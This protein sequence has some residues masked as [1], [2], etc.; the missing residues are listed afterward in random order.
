VRLY[1]KNIF[2]KNSPFRVLMI[3][4]IKRLKEIIKLVLVNISISK[5]FIIGILSILFIYYLTAP[6]VYFYLGGGRAFIKLFPRKWLGDVSTLVTMKF[7]RPVINDF[8]LLTSNNL[9]C[10]ENLNHVPFNNCNFLLTNDFSLKVY[11]FKVVPGTFWVNIHLSKEAGCPSEIAFEFLGKRQNRFNRR[12]QQYD[13]E[14]VRF[15]KRV[16]IIDNMPITIPI[17]LSSRDI[18]RKTF[19]FKLE[20]I[21]GCNIN[22]TRV[23]VS[24]RSAFCGGTYSEGF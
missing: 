10:K 20:L 2:N 18:D 21:S 24:N 1:F 13:R 23:W 11:D 4:L 15:A 16:Q 8:S 22:L 12:K 17:K 14:I 3:D 9:L 6:A 7:L 19:S 5:T